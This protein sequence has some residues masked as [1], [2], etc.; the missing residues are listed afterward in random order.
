MNFIIAE[1]QKAIFE[2][3]KEEVAE[4]VINIQETR[5]EFEGQ[6]TIVVFPITKI[7]K[8]S[9]EQTATEI[10]EYLVANVADITKFNVVKGFLNLSIAES[11]FLKQFNE[12]ILSPDFGVYAPNGKKVMVEYSSPNTNKPLHLGHVRNNLLGYSV[13]ELLKAYGYD[14]VKV[15]LVND[16]GIH[17][18]KS[19][20][21]WQKWGNGETP[22]STGLKGDHLVGKYYVIFDKEYKKE[23]DTLK[24]EGQTEEEAKKNAPLIK[25]A[26]QMLLKWEQGDEEVVSLWKTMNEW[27]YAGFNVTYKNLGVDFDKFYYE[28]NTYLL[29]KGTVD[30]GLAKG[31]F[32]KKEDGSVWIDLTADGLD[33][34]LVLRADGT[35]V[36]ITQ[37]LGTAEMKHDD[38]NMDESIYVVG[39]EQDYHFKVLFLILEKLGKSWA[40]GLYHL[41]YGM[42]D[43]PNGKMK[44]R[45]GTVVDADELIESMVTT[46]REKTEEL[47][48]TNDFSEADKEELYKNIGLGA[49]K[50][51]LLKVEPK[52]RLLFNPAE[53]ID[54]QGNTGP[55]IQY[56]HARIKSLLSKSDYKFSVGSLAYSGISDVELEMILQ[57][58]KYPAEIAIAAK[59]YSPASL[60]NYLYELAKLFNK[61]YHEVP[62]IVKTEEGEA[63][64]FRLNLSKKTADIIH[65]G[66]LILG[67]TSPERM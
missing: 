31:V 21:A 29:G 20:L 25:E 44:S 27:V 53:S 48:K 54:F 17:I 64:Q 57:L 2:L 35:S 42:V 18:C 62:P 45:E 60:A 22:E 1:T 58:A 37:D 38:F 30:E 52:K 11:Y 47:G 49:L 9:P 7:S 6:A 15:N 26:Q 55:F 24:A 41:S 63:K 43:L 66:M 36:Y 51:F 16:R 32:F 67:I 14:V 34:K 4:S 23:I 65:A 39:N 19:M 59:A 28:S 56:T 33:Q 8:K 3:Y 50:Y 40:K 10:G 46:A 12:E 13:S 61:F 5:K